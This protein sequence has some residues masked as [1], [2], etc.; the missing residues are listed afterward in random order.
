M[1]LLARSRPPKQKPRHF[2]TGSAFQLMYISSGGN[3]F[4]D[5][6]RLAQHVAA[7]PDGLDEVAAFGGVGE[8]LAQLA[9]EDVDHL[10]FG[11]SRCP[12]LTQ[13]TMQIP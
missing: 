4:F 6:V 9:D 8:L 10:Q 1:T 2:V 12:L 13:Q 11:W 3:A 7:S 5:L